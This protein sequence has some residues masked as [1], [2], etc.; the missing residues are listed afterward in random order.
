M[1]YIIAAML[2]YTLVIMAGAIASRNADFRIVNALANFISAVIPIGLVIAMFG[3]SET[4]QN[5]KIGIIFAII[6]GIAVAIFG[7][8]LTKSY[9]TSKVAIVAPIVFGGSI[10]LSAILSAIIFKERVSTVQ[11]VGLVLLGLGLSLI[12]YAKATNS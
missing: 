2:F 5:S 3:K 12:I 1:T 8:A 7:L 6:T 4:F 11:F 9:V 10:F